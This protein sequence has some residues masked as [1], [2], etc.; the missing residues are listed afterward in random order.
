MTQ[1]DAINLQEKQNKSFVFNKNIV[2][3]FKKLIFVFTQV[4][5]LV[6]FDLKNYICVEINVLK[7]VIIVIF[8]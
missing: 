7:F 2:I 3:A 4:F 5:M 1:L 8:S 6:H